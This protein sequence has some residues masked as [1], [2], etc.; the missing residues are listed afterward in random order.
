[1]CRWRRSSE[2]APRCRSGC[3]ELLWLPGVGD[4]G[5]GP[6]AEMLEQLDLWRRHPAAAPQRHG[7]LRSYLARLEPLADRL[8]VWRDELYLELHRGC[9]TSRPDQKR[10]NRTLERLLREAELTAALIPGDL[11]PAATT[12][13]RP[14]LF[15]QFHDILPGTS[16]PEV[17]E[18]AEPLWRSARRRACRQRDALL[19]TL[20]AH[21]LP[22]PLPVHNVARP[23]WAMQLQPLAAVPRTVRLPA[24]HWTL[25][26]Q[27]GEIGLEGQPAPGGGQWVQLPGFEGIEA[28]CLLQ[29][30]R[31]H[32]AAAPPQPLVDP[33]EVRPCAETGPDSGGASWRLTNG[34]LAVRIG[35]RGIEQLWDGEGRAQL[36]APLR[37]CRWRDRGEY[38]DA[39]DL[40]ADH[41][42]HPLPW[43][44]E[45]DPLWLERGPLCARFLWRGRCGTSPTRLEGRL[46]AGSP[47]LELTLSLDWQQRHELLR[48]EIPLRQP[49]CRWAADTPAGV[50][51]RPTVAI[52]ARE[53]AR[54]E[55]PTISW[56][57]SVTGGAAGG[58]LAVLLDGPQG[59][60][61]DEHHLGVSL[62]RGPT[63]PDP[64]A[65]NGWQRQRL[66]LMPCPR[67]WR[68]DQVPRQAQRLREPLWIRP[69]AT[70]GGGAAANVPA[71][72]RWSAFPPLEEDLRLI[73][74]RPDTDGNLKLCI[75][76]EGPCRRRLRLPPP[77]RLLGRLDGLGEERSGAATP[78]AEHH[79]REGEPVDPWLGPWQ[80]GFWRLGV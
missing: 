31:E 9:A 19:Q 36:A 55:V 7:S 34:R 41:R 53:Q 75:Q 52:T 68:Q 10:H 23:W 50:I 26:D 54:W 74:L 15:Q 71:A 17:F 48:L 57:A 1:R 27:Q 65:D 11:R 30:T 20:L 18:Q 8:P 13:W 12:D 66:A 43:Y 32:A 69:Q 78:A 44:W 51:E 67:G 62:L 64:G 2:P 24:G 29:A 49:A 60:C 5:G 33:V 16:I 79:R 63:W 56:L 25:L 80:L 70:T 73:A 42:R 22:P 59:V 40:A 61:G 76:N 21:T 77:W 4:H 47:W 58:G 46:L 37:W 45:G 38:W 39:W 14:L 72:E 35:W 28:C 6:T 3:D